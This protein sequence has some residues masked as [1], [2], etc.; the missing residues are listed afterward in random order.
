M[1]TSL[2]LVSGDREMILLPRAGLK[3]QGLDVP[4]AA[5]REQVEARTDDD[6]EDDTTEYYGA[7]SCSLELLAEQTPEAFRAELDAFLHPRTRPYLVAE[8]DEWAQARRLRLRV[9][10]RTDPRTT[11]LPRTMRRIQVQ[12]R[13]PD[14]VWEAAE[15][16]T[17]P[18]IGADVP[19]T[20]GRTYPKTYP[21]AYTP[22]MSVG[23][24]LVTNLGLIP[25][26][27]VARLYGPCTAPR[28]VNETLGE[29]IAFTSDLALDAGE[30]V[31]IDTRDKTAYL[32][33]MP[34]VSRLNQ[35]DFAVTSWWR[36]EPGE[37]Q[38]RYAPA[39]ASAGAA[40][41]IEYRP[42]WL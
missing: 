35:I 1:L 8:D 6:G 34:G 3:V 11:Q 9:T 20:V 24:S 22:T 26:H 21:W 31:E 10:Q 25:S 37:Q 30:Y 17:V 15:P 19:S 36:I 28:L 5:P 33:S 29:E 42:A 2:K 40:A 39:S 27:F 38:I 7:A 14:G 4:Q 32:L 16:T 13:V 12:W 41:Q 23:A 18:D